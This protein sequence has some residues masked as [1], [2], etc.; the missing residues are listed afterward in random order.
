MPPKGP[1]LSVAEQTLLRRWIQDG[2][3]WPEFRPQPT[4]LA[5]ACSDLAFLRRVTYD[6]VGVPP[7][8]A[9]IA[10]FEADGSPDKRSR[11]IDRL[12][13]DPRSHRFREA[14]LD[15]WLDLRKMEDSTPSTTLYNDYYLDDA[16]AEAQRD[17]ARLAE[18]LRIARAQVTHARNMYSD[19]R[20]EVW[21]LA[22][23]GIQG[24]E[25]PLDALENVVR[26]A[27]DSDD[28]RDWERRNE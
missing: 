15:Y 27:E 10:A 19:L 26:A 4:R 23:A 18:M 2:A 7:S 5:P 8:T 24:A 14:F 6:V 20:Y 17:R 21:R 13:A 11:A 22:Q 16:L 9:E 25:W 1:G 28:D 12:L 3:H